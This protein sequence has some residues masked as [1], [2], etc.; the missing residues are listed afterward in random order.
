M[1]QLMFFSEFIKIQKFSSL[2]PL[3]Q[4]DSLGRDIAN[5]FYQKFKNK[6][7][8]NSSKDKRQSI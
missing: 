1:T 3:N 4:D 6:Q 8:K 5:E 2:M 7:S